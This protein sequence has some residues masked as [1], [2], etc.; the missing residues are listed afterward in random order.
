MVHLVK[1][2]ISKNLTMIVRKTDL[3]STTFVPLDLSFG[4]IS[5]WTNPKP[6]SIRFCRPIR[7]QYLKESEAILKFEKEYI[8][9]QINL[10]EDSEFELINGLEVIVTK[11]KFNLKLTMID[12]KAANAICSTSSQQVCNICSASPKQMNSIACGSLLTPTSNIDNIELGL[13]P[14]HAR[15]RCFEC[16]LHISYRLEIKKWQIHGNDD[17]EVCGKKKTNHTK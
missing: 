17:K 12:G 6:S 10:L 15:I 7:V 2:N 5:V 13:S 3:F 9:N 11:V 4:N 8:Q 16:L 1:V 14:L